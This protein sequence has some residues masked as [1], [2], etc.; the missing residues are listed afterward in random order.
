MKI[1]KPLITALALVAGLAQSPAF[2]YEITTASGKKMNVQ[3]LGWNGDH[4]QLQS[5]RGHKHVVEMKNLGED[6]EAYIR[7]N[8]PRD[9]EVAPRILPRSYTLTDGRE[10]EGEVLGLKGLQV[11]IKLKN[12]KSGTV[13]LLQFSKKDQDYFVQNASHL[14]ALNANPEVRHDP[15][16]VTK[17]VIRIDQL[18]NRFYKSSKVRANP[19]VDDATFLRR[20]YLSIIGRVP[21]ATEATRFLDDTSKTKRA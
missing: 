10:I 17:A 7:K 19:L 15:A 6:T 5:P 11:A 1:R 13:P 20:A 12:G 14:D 9:Y 4:V 16:K 21:N 2:G 3:F 18:M 8:I